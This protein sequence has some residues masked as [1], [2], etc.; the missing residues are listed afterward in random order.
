MLMCKYYINLL[1]RKNRF[2]KSPVSMNMLLVY[3]HPEQH[4]SGWGYKS[5]LNGMLLLTLPGHDDFKFSLLFLAVVIL[6]MKIFLSQI[7]DN[8]SILQFA[9]VKGL[10]VVGDCLVGFFN[11]FLKSGFLSEESA[12]YSTVVTTSSP[13]DYF[14]LTHTVCVSPKWWKGLLTC[15]SLRK[16]YL[17]VC[18]LS[19]VRCSPPKV[20]Y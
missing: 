18:S 5:K 16:I 19:S 11:E 9:I 2:E 3:P 4:L 13:Y 7:I 20:P 6:T 17:T 12:Y 8:D 15:K 10:H 1:K 14:R